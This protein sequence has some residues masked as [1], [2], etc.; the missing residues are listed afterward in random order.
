LVTSQANGALQLEI[1][2]IAQPFQWTFEPQLL[3]SSSDVDQH[4]DLELPDVCD[5]DERTKSFT[6]EAQL[7]EQK[8]KSQN[9]ISLNDFEL[10]VEDAFE[11]SEMD[12][13]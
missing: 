4:S 11:N 8:S 12:T 10:N 5:F 7:Q 13:L 3:T 2:L 1:I 6:N 9:S